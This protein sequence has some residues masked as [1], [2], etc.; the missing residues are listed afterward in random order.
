MTTAHLWT[1]IKSTADIQTAA[2]WVLFLSDAGHTGA[3]GGPRG[4]RPSR[5]EGEA[6]FPP[7]QEG[8]MARK[9][10]REIVGGYT[11]KREMKRAREANDAAR[12]ALTKLHEHI[13]GE[14]NTELMSILV[15]KAALALGENAAALAELEEIGR[16]G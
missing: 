3:A 10:R 7:P 9:R 8:T 6:D 2:M 5:Q 15:A 1:K 14:T 13:S 4:K 16:G 12:A 11:W